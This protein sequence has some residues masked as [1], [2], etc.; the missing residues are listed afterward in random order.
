MEKYGPEKLRIQTLYAVISNSDYKDLARSI[1][2]DKVLYN[3]AFEIISNPQYNGYERINLHQWF[4]HFLINI[5]WWWNKV[6][7]YAC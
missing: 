7:C 1:D 6:S 5:L 3:K 2:P 4:I